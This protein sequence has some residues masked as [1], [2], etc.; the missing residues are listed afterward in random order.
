MARSLKNIQKGTPN[1]APF[2]YDL[3]WDGKSEIYFSLLIH[4]ETEVLG[5]NMSRLGD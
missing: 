2:L 1:G 5:E 4:P 3:R